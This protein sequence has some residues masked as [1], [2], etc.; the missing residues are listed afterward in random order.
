MKLKPYHLLFVI[1]IG[2]FQTN[3]T[4]NEKDNTPWVSLFD[5]KTFEGW[6]QKG[7]EAKYSIRDRIIVG[8]TV[9][10]TPNSFMTT[11][12]MYGDFILELE[13]KVDST[14]NSGIQIRSN[15]FPYYKNGRVHG[16][17]IEIDPSKR[18]WSAGIYDEGRRGW[19]NPLSDNP[20]AQ[21]AFKQNEWNHYRIEAIGDTLKTWINNV[22]AAYLID[23]A[24]DSGFIGLQVHSIGKDHKEGTE[25]QWKNIKILTDSLAKYSKKSPLKPIITENNL[26]GNQ[27]KDGWKLLWDGKTT[28][29]WRGAKLKTFPEKG[30][31]IENGELTVLASGGGE[32]EAGGDIVTTE[33]YSDFEL[34]LDFKLTEGANSGIKYYVDTELNKGAGSSIGLEYQILDDAKHPDAK[35]GNHE[36]SR[37]VASLYDLIQADPNKHVNL[38]GEWNNARIISK[39]NHVEHWLNGT[40]VLEYERK[41]DAYRKLVS[42]SKYVDWK[43]FGEAETGHILLQD[44]GDRVS[45]KNIKIKPL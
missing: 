36:G 20:K 15:S 21:Q 24:T 10:N 39:N 23:D 16:Y 4:K 34:Q 6:T 40:K 9:H 7:G 14:M 44:H 32:S 12:K 29:G 30:W 17:Q 28:N 11:N 33:K 25:I 1:V 2:L 37:T 22:P 13:Y 19:L 18:A 45:F 5:G 3:C 38:I 43:N 8:T 35:L 27:A 41:S 42:E 31:V 26:I